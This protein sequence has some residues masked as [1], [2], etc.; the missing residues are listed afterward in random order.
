MFVH[1]TNSKPF[2]N[3]HRP[4]ASSYSLFFESIRDWEFVV[5]SIPA[6]QCRYT[7]RVGDLFRRGGVPPSIRH[8]VWSYLADSASERVDGLYARLRQTCLTSASETDAPDLTSKQSETSSHL[9]VNVLK[10]YRETEMDAQHDLGLV[11]IAG[12]ILTQYSMQGNE[13]DA[14]WAFAS[15]INI[16]DPHRIHEYATQFAQTL[17]MQDHVLA[18]RLFVDLGVTSLDLCSNWISTLFIGILPI[19]HLLLV[20]DRCMFE[21]RDACSVSR[22]Y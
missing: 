9:L 1:S 22:I 4:R 10:A 19:D 15:L 7:D 16:L 6:A 2:P 12:F 11:S 8:R 13:E 20:W 5:L 14:F 18:R 21:G 3:I 17:N